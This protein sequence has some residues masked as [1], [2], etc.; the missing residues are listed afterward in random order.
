MDI[1]STTVKLVIL[2]S[3]N[4][5]VLRIGRK[6][7]MTNLLHR[8]G[9][10]SHHSNRIYRIAMIAIWVDIVLLCFANRDRFT[11]E[12]ISQLTPAN[13]FAAFCVFIGLFALKSISIVIYSGFLYAASGILFPFPMALLVD[14]CG[15]AVMYAIPYWVG[16]KFGADTLNSITEKYPKTAMLRSLRAKNDFR[17]AMLARLIGVI[18]YDVAS[19]YLGADGVKFGPYLLGSLC[20]FFPSMMVLS[21]IGKSAHD[22]GSPAF[23]LSTAI[24]LLSMGVSGAVCAILWKRY[25]QISKESNNIGG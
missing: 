7:R 12:G 8:D 4:Q 24:E 3:N 19:L 16:R 20:G 2:D 18:P 13:R 9:M 21:F 25:K 11:V 15:S 10:P 6:C 14:L 5:I 22:P 17:Y 1:G 23:L